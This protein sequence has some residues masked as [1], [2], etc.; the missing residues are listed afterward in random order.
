MVGRRS[1]GVPVSCTRARSTHGR[2]RTGRRRN[3]RCIERSSA[4]LAVAQRRVRERELRRRAPPRLPPLTPPRPRRW[5][6]H[7][8]DE[9][10]KR[11]LSSTFEQT[12]GAGQASMYEEG[13]EG[14]GAR[15]GYGNGWR[16]G[17]RKA[18]PQQ[19]DCDEQEKRRRR[20]RRRRERESGRDEY[21]GRLTTM[22]RMQ[23]DKLPVSLGGRI[24]EVEYNLS[25]S[26]SSELAE[27]CTKHDSRRASRR[28]RSASSARRRPA[29]AARAPRL[30]GHHTVLR[31]WPREA[32]REV[33]EKEASDFVKSFEGLL[34]KWALAMN[35]SLAAWR[36]REGHAVER[37]TLLVSHRLP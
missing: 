2:A 22:F 1:S 27:R 19:A 5:K 25:S 9:S 14:R 26:I 17:R 11:D 16:V 32:R 20:E 30:E 10:W 35:H 13:G 31:S 23:Y 37:R 33:I 6:G 7:N 24:G 3:T 29:R 21:L 28:S 4:G 12:I 8:S 18:A 34:R 36:H 15:G